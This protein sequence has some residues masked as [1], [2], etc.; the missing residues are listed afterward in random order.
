[1]TRVGHDW[2]SGEQQAPDYAYYWYTRY[3]V[4]APNERL[5]TLPDVR[6]Q[7]TASMGDCTQTGP[8]LSPSPVP[9]SSRSTAVSLAFWT[10]S[11]VVAVHHLFKTGMINRFSSYRCEAG[12]WLCLIAA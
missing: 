6:T 5:L 12:Q 11:S 10:I 1:M 2:V 7:S 3:T 9:T 8:T 4:G